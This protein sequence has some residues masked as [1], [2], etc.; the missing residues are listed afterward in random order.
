MGEQHRMDFGTR[1]ELGAEPHGDRVII[2]LAHV[3]QPPFGRMEMSQQEADMLAARIMLASTA[4]CHR[5]S[6]EE[7]HAAHQVL[8]RTVKPH[9]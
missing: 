9:A 8:A 2:T 7:V 1:L 3:G 4:A 6:I 5:V